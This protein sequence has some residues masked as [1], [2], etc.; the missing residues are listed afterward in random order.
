MFVFGYTFYIFC[1]T[2]SLELRLAA[3]ARWLTSRKAKAEARQASRQKVQRF[4]AWHFK[5]RVERREQSRSASGP[6]LSDL[7]C[8]RVPLILLRFA[9]FGK[10]VFVTFI[11]KTKKTGKNGEVEN[12]DFCEF[13]ADTRAFSQGHW[14]R[15]TRNGVQTT[16][17]L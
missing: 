1:D 5:G 13:R 6:L 8:C 10:P 3:L 2:M 9:A 16:F 4:S 15:K 7:L 12:L 14:E 11:R 17:R